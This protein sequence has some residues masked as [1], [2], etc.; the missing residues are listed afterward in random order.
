MKF[1][2]LGRA[3]VSDS[4]LQGV[5]EVRVLHRD[6]SFEDV[7]ENF[8]RGAHRGDFRDKFRGVVLEDRTGLSIVDLESPS[9]DPLVGVIE[10]VL[11]DGPFL[12]ALDHRV[13][14]GAHEMNDREDVEV[15]RQ[16]FGLSEVS[17]DAVEDEEIDLGFEKAQ[18]RLGMHVLTPHLDGELVGDEFA[19]GGEVEKLGAKIA[20]GIQRAEDITTGKM[21][22]PRDLAENLALSPL[23]GSRGAEKKNGLVSIRHRVVLASING[24]VGSARGV[25][26]KF[27]PGESRFRRNSSL[28]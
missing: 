16:C 7:L 18:D 17:W 26:D 12:H 4:R 3:R 6:H 24:G 22:E 10:A 2:D 8:G 11:L 21:E 19:S 15:R 28:L 5:V 14:V 13:E 23:A 20:G 25:S 1:E 27:Q 9:D